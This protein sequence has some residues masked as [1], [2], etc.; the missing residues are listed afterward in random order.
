M[1]GSIFVGTSVDGFIAK[2]DGGLDW[3]T[4]GGENSE[5][6]EEAGFS[7]FMATVDAL[8]M[9]RNTFDI[10]AKFARWPYGAKPVIVLSTRPPVASPAGAVVEWMSGEPEEIV[11]RL[12]RR[13][14]EHLYI[15][16]GVTIQRFLRAGL[17]Q[18]L[19]I[20]QVP[21][22]IGEGIPLFG[23]TGRDIRLRHLATRE[24]SGGAVKSE[25]E[26]VG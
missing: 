19:T 22:L 9:G 21:V 26:V 24:L 11:A 4:G 5:G 12:A 13:G 14:F 15:D 25:Y 23:P 17:I 8:V 18:R 1:R 6:S 16:G 3:L 20:T 7:D 10:V 2:P